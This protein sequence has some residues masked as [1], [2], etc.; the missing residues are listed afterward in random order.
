MKN[1]TIT[2]SDVSKPIVNINDYL[3]A[4]GEG[5][6]QRIVESFPPLHD[7]E[8]SVSPLLAKL[9]R[10]PYA[11]QSLAVM[12]IVRRWEKSRSA[13]A[14]AECGTGKTF[15]ALASMFVHSQG[16][17]FCG[18]V[19]ARHTL[20]TNGRASRSKPYRACACS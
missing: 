18:L 20:W 12:G 9:R 5:L 13:A 11:A 7:V 2:L 1:T 15:I 8:D 19:M 14:V 16:K 10:E 3:T 6:A 17:P 4:Y